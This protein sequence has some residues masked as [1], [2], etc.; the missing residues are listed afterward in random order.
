MQAVVNLDP[1]VEEMLRRKV[2]ERNLDFDRALNDALRAGLS[3]EGGE[4]GRRFVQKTYSCGPER[5]DLTKA[6]ALADEL[7]DEEAIRKMRIFEGR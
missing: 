4:T 1:D 6:Q 2:L 7:T 3:S 5:V